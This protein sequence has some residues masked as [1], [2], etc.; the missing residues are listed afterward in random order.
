MFSEGFVRLRAVNLADDHGRKLLAAFLLMVSLLGCVLALPFSA[1]H[2]EPGAL[3][4]I[5]E[6]ITGSGTTEALPGVAPL[7]N[8]DPNEAVVSMRPTGVTALYPATAAPWPGYSSSYLAGCDIALAG[9]LVLT[10]LA[11]IIWLLHPV[12]G[13]WAWEPRVLFSR[14]LGLIPR[15]SLPTHTPSLIALSISRT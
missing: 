2:A 1:G 4:V 13:A 3:P 5:S 12:I 14:L 11:L 9:S 8:R 6:H 7:S 15:L 10:G